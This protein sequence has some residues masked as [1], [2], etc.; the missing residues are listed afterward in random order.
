MIPDLVKSAGTSQF[1][2]GGVLRCHSKRVPQFEFSGGMMMKTGIK[3][4]QLPTV[5]S[6]PK[7]VSKGTGP[8]SN[9]YPIASYST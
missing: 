4:R 7:K 9:R 6:S 3:V 2:T 1:C 8:V 5:V